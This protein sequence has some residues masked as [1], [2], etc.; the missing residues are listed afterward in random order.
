[1][2]E[3]GAP[4]ANP[5]GALMKNKVSSG[6][7]K[8]IIYSPC[9]FIIIG[10]L[11]LSF[12]CFSN[13]THVFLREDFDSLDEWKPLYFAKI[14]N[15]SE[16]TIEHQGEETFL[17]AESDS[18]ASG[19]LFKKEFNVFQYPKARWRWKVN[20]VYRKGNA[21]EKSGDDYP[22]RIYIIFKYNPETAS[23]GKK[24]KYGLAKKLYG[25]YPPDSTLNYIWA[26]RK[27]VRKIMANT[28]AE[29][30]QMIILQSGP[31]NAGTWLLQEVN[32]LADYQK[33]F[34]TDPPETA[35]LAIMNDSDNTGESSVSYVDFIEV[36]R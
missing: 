35:S 19:I 29:E 23:L 34:G 14:K 7:L 13:D 11:V 31:Q 27:H 15:H 36:F 26:N 32:V 30:A 8:K 18:S 10:I 22:I 3:A 33:A 20:N 12:P 16:Y 6:L 2:K 24:V 5:P 9:T 28:Y 17:R 4:A 25:D 1:M 21:R